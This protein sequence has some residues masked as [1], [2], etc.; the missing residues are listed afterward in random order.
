MAD[1]LLSAYLAVGEDKFKREFVQQRIRQRVAREGDIDF[2]CETFAGPSAQGDEIVSACNTL[3]FMSGYRL[4]IVNDAD[5]LSSDAREALVKYLD[6]P[7]ETTVLFLDATKLAK[8][9]RLYKAVAKVGKKAVI[10]CSLKRGRA[11]SKQI[12]DFARSEGVQITPHAADR[13]F[14]LVGSSTVHQHGEIKKMAIALGRGAVIDVPQVDEFVTRVSEVKPWIFQDAFCERDVEKTAVLLARMRT[15]D[16]YSPIGTLAQAVR[17]IRELLVAKD[18]RGGGVGAV[19]R[20][21]GKPEFQVKNHQRFAANFR[22]GELE[23]A[24]VAAADCDGAMKSGGDPDLLLERWT[25]T[26]CTGR[27]DDWGLEG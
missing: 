24:L 4:V 8:N 19:A 3:P 12:Q 5:K 10:D 22:P 1:T 27:W 20:A 16:S 25:L 17:R 18:I 26:V 15:Q 23:R 11:A 2:N 9:T 13:L 7:S 14:S 6:A 21:L